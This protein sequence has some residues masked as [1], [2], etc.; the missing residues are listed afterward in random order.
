MSGFYALV[1]NDDPTGNPTME[2]SGDKGTY[3]GDG[4]Y[5][6]R[7]ITVEE[8]EALANDLLTEAHA[9]RE[10]RDANPQWAR[11]SYS[12]GLNDSYFD[13]SAGHVC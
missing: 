8:M 7:E 11:R 9:I 10:A 2:F 3:N 1:P 4:W 5:A 12:V 13:M 6:V